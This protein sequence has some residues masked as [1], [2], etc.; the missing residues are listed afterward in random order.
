MIKDNIKVAKKVLITIVIT[1]L[2]VIFFSLLINTS[3]N[4]FINKIKNYTENGI[5]VLYISDKNNYRS[6]PIELFNK[7][8]V[9]YMY[10][11]SLNLSNLEKSKLSKLINSQYLS[12]IIVVFKDGIVSDAIISYSNEEALNNFLSKNEL[13]PNIIGDNSNIISR[14]E[15]LLDS[16]YMIL[17]LP[18]E[19][20]DTVLEQNDILSSIARQH[21]INYEMVNAYLLSET[22][23][24]NLNSLLKISKVK[25]QIVIFIK[26]SKIFG[27]I[28][29]INT[30]ISYLNR[31]NEIKFINDIGNYI[32]NINYNNF[33]DLLSSQQ[34]N[35]IIIGRDDSKYCEDNIKI[36]N[37]ICSEYNID[38][39]YL[40]VEKDDSKLFL[41]VKEKLASIGYNDSYTLPLTI[42]VEN[43]KLIEYIIGA[44]NKNYY[45]DIFKEN[46]II[47]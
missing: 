30:R 7:Y 10:I 42:I 31:L 5:K 36:L 26:D 27:S 23:K 2:L 35:I 45:I 8:D 33:E 9:D 37:D 11:N 21:S 17:Y 13:I 20:S 22:Q 6:Y 29:G 4:N 19:N 24:E 15:E 14:V 25:D 43:N 41:N 34:K 12:D 28:R 44:S 1:L 40:N 47:K 46:G 39:N 38:I 32:L 16:N 18:Y 3:T